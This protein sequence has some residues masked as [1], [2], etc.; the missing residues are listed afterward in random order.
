MALGWLID[1]LRGPA[2]DLV[3]LALA[4]AAAALAARVRGKQKRT[5]DQLREAGVL[6]E[7]GQSVQQ[8]LGSRRSESSSRTKR[9]TP[10]P[11]PLEREPL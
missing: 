7:R 3:Q 1:A 2:A 10:S 11:A 8:L 9:R 4:A 5:N 6:P